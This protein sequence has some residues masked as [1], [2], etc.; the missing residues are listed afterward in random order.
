[1][2]RSFEGKAPRIHASAFVS[3]TAYVIGDVE[4][5]ERATI[6]PGVVIRGDIGRIVIGS[7]THIEDNSVIHGAPNGTMTIGSNCTI[8]HLVVF[9]GDRVGDY[10]L[11]GNGA[12]VLDGATIGRWS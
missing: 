4:I 7:E 9:H 2:I 1:M 11:V 5:G 6:W 12:I 10:S 8:G 3:E